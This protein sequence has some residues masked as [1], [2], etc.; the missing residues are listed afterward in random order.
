MRLARRLCV[1]NEIC[2]FLNLC[3]S[4]DGAP[5]P[6]LFRRISIGLSGGSPRCC[7][8]VQTPSPRNL[9]NV[10]PFAAPAIR[11]GTLHAQE[12]KPPGLAQAA[13]RA[14]ADVIRTG[15][16]GQRLV[17][18]L[19]TRDGFAALVQRQF[20]RAAEQHTTGLGALAALAGAGN[21][22][23]ALELGEWSW[24]RSLLGAVPETRA[25]S[26]PPSVPERAD[27]RG[28]NQVCAG[29][30]QVLLQNVNHDGP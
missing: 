3:V 8:H 13:D 1:G 7:R 27:Q 12:K 4:E 20:E 26:Q 16:V 18:T 14:V 19:A 11:P 22:Q 29:A 2:R 15:D 28:D 9:R 10:P 23:V 5:C 21:D 6:R 24:L 30:Q 25:G 17:A